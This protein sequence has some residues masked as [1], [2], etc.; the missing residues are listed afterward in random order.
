MNTLPLPL[1]LAAFIFVV[2][3]IALLF[4]RNIVKLLMGITLIEA[5]VNLFLVA[6]GYRH[7]AIAPIFTSAPAH[8]R[9]ALP[10]MQ[11]LTLTAIVI[12]V[13]TSA[14]MLAFA[15]VLYRR[16]GTTNVTKMKEMKG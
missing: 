1:F 10:T 3:L 6:L 8:A 16:Y 14:M 5:A 2:G 15:I 12:G 13:A 7:D 11:A 9:M 4:K